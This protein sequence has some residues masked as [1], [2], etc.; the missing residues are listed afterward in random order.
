MF[1]PDPGMAC[2]S[3]MEDRRRLAVS[4]VD[5]LAEYCGGPRSGSRCLRASSPS[6]A[7]DAP[8]PACPSALDLL[9]VL[10]IQQALAAFPL[11]AALLC[12]CPGG[13]AVWPEL[14]FDCDCGQARHGTVQQ[15]LI[16]LADFRRGL[17]VSN[18]AYA[19]VVKG[20]A[21]GFPESANGF[22][23]RGSSPLARIFFGPLLLLPP[24]LFFFR[25]SFSS[26]D[27]P[28]PPPLPP[29]LGVHKKE[30]GGY[31]VWYFF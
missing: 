1:L 29:I 30:T 31:R 10:P 4:A 15:L 25:G 19:R 14:R 21:L 5:F 13:G 12:S 6:C 16:D 8:G 3:I 2:A 11:P 20:L 26:A 7:G 28:P 22:G 27:A 17:R 9:S 18:R 23:R 24:P